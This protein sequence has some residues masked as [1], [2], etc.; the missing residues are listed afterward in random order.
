VFDYQSMLGRG[1]RPAIDGEDSGEAGWEIIV[2]T[3]PGR[4]RIVF[5]M[6]E[7]ATPGFDAA[8]DLP[9]PPPAPTGNPRP[10]L[11]LTRPEW[12]LST[13]AH[14]R[15][16]FT[17]PGTEEPL[18]KAEVACP[19]PGPVTLHWNSEAWPAELDW[20]IYLPSQNRVVVLSMREQQAVTLNV[21][22]D[23]LPLQFRLPGTLT[24]A[25]PT[26]A[27]DLQLHNVPN[28]FNPGTEFRFNL[29]QAGQVEVHI[30]NIRGVRVNRLVAGLLPV[31]PATLAWNG[32][33]RAGASVASGA[34][35]YRLFLDGQQLGSV[36]KMTLVK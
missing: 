10:R 6:R 14:F 27:A 5:G 19:E 1:G 28:P 9:L 35:F 34:Y 30:Y 33:D 24:D 22:T 12:G 17:A 15:A 21:G 29:P 32:R 16:D 7:G 18:W 20:Q 26:L 4:S 2:D 3:Q 31:G 23:P 8:Y 11:Y 13:G 36:R 25:P